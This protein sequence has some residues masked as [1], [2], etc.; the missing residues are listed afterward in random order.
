MQITSLELNNIR[1]YKGGHSLNC[2]STI[3]IFIGPNNAGKSTILNSIKIIQYPYFIQKDI[4]IG[5]TTGSIEIYGNSHDI[6]LDNGTTLPFLYFQCKLRSDGPIETYFNGQYPSSLAWKREP[7][8]AIYP[9]LSRRKVAG[10]SLD[11]GETA[12]STVHEN[13]THLYAKVDRLSD[14]EFQPAHDEFR[15]ACKDVLGYNVSTVTKDNGKHAIYTIHNIENIPLSS[16]GEGVANIVALIADL[17]MA[18]NK[19]FLIEELENDIHPSALKALLKFIE[20]KSINNQFFISTHSNIVM[21]NLGAIQN[22]KIFSVRND[23]KDEQ[24]S[25]LFLSEIRE[26][27]E[28]PEE[29][30]QVLEDLGYDFFDYDLWKGWLFLEESSAEVII[31]E[32]LIRWFVPELA[33][34][35]RTFS[36]GSVDKVK[37]KFDDFNKLF[38]FLHLE[39]SYKDKVW[40][41]IDGGEHEGQI[42]KDFQKTYTAWKS[43]N[44]NQ[45]K[46][47]DFEKYYPMQ[48]LDEV[49]AILKIT[50]KQSKRFEKRELLEKVKTWSNENPEDAKKAFKESAK[51]VIDVLRKI[52]KELK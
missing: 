42:I 23:L 14:R 24:R 51:E 52:L 32:Y 30:R 43:E 2:S 39:P 20:K 12:T 5:Q 10:Y 36:A 45:F 22:A 6:K 49:D 1:S 11:I 46:E 38:V 19:I 50:D 26:L 28:R 8:N 9:Y 21:K 27:S 3:N 37:L 47:H 29:R 18:E 16:M 25:R 13:F 7:D 40:V 31:R 34:K 4:T 17:C 33:T 48:F 15:E 41:Y 35:I 44:F